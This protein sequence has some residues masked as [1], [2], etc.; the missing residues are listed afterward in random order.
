MMPSRL[1]ANTRNIKPE[2]LIGRKA[3]NLTILGLPF[4]IREKTRETYVVVQCDCGDISVRRLNHIQ[5][6]WNK[7]LLHASCP[8]CILKLSIKHGSAIRSIDGTNNQ[9]RLY[10]IWAGMRHRCSTS[11]KSSKLYK[12]Y[13]SKNITVCEEWLD[14]RKFKIWAE[15]NGYYEE[16]DT[17]NKS[18]KLSIDRIDSKQGYN[19]N[20]CRWVSGRE[21]SAN[22]VKERD[23]VI[24]LLSYQISIY[25]EYA[26]CGLI[27]PPSE[28]INEIVDILKLTELSKPWTPENKKRIVDYCNGKV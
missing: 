14:F 17:I 8:E 15:S 16:D 1:L 22:V 23:K 13:A 20:N 12:N 7:K 18:D 19:P 11:N 4:G 27:A 25:E 26:Y 24:N 9:T 6:F 5:L 21:N 3:G 2:S 10:G 28:K